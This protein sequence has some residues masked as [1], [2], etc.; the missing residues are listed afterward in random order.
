MMILS[1]SIFL[2]FVVIIILVI[3][4]VYCLQNPRSV[5]LDDG[6]RSELKFS[7]LHPPRLLIKISDPRSSI[8]QPSRPNS[9]HPQ[10]CHPEFL[11]VP[12]RPP[13]T[14][15]IL[16]STING[17]DTV[18]CP[19]PRTHH[20]TF[21]WSQSLSPTTQICSRSSPASSAVSLVQDLQRGR[22]G[23]LLEYPCCP[24][25]KVQ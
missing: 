6:V 12:A 13:P 4:E 17:I 10:H 11:A 22:S 23:S 25:H 20:G 1:L 8:R 3:F 21:P 19:E 24:V 9:G 16:A 14:P 18:A 5:F 2:E 15:A 7:S